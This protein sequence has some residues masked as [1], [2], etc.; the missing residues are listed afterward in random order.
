MT[1]KSN[2]D[3]PIGRERYQRLIAA[4]QNQTKI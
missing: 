1:E 3:E 2:R 4:A